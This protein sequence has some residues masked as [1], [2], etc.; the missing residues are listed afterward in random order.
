MRRSAAL[1]IA[2]RLREAGFQAYLAGGCVRDEVMGR[3]ARDYDVAT[4]A[5]PERVQ[6]LF[7]R[8]A[9]VGVAFGVVLVL[10]EGPPT[11]VATFRSEGG[12][13]DGRH[14]DRVS[15][16]DAR[17]DVSR[18]DFTING[19][20]Q[21][22]VTGEVLDWVG[23]R[24]D[25]A[26]RVVRAIGDPEVR[27][28][29]DRLRMLR[30]VR[31]ASELGFAIDPSLADAIRAQA[32]RIRTI[33]A[34]RIR[35]ELT[36]LLCRP[37]RARGLSLLRET[38]LLK[39]I[40]PE[41]S[42]MDGVAQPEQFHPEGDVW[43]HTVLVMEKLPDEEVSPTLAWGALLHDVGKPPTYR[44][45]P[46]RI[47]FD[48]HDR[49]GAQM[50]EGIGKRLR[51]SNDQIERICWLVRTH[52]LF[53]DVPNMRPARLRRFLSEPGFD[54]ALALH[55]ADCLAS[56]GLLDRHAFCLHA[57]QAYGK[58]PLRPP[59]LLTGHDLIALGHKPGPAFKTIL[60]AAETE[61]LE[62]RLSD[63]EAALGWV[64]MKYPAG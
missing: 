31:F 48:G 47:R 8:T 57:L 25:I 39:P 64:R 21:D 55:H 26:A 15:F 46:D 38:G 41:L 42:A 56:H 58:E 23:G 32:P 18:R 1:R 49:I 43:V 20:L 60:E 19:L 54:E 45:A 28:G 37:G 2:L 5:P 6:A 13:A 10:D 52:L 4:D 22:P 59:P 11:E 53:K 34:E 9:G 24:A 27:I 36:K 33:S 50:S 12:Y 3:P 16:C 40:L 51:F 17:G 29:E 35:D 62:G 61:Q 7:R 63:R 14:P 30:A 44:E